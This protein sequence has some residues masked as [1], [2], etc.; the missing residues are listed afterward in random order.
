[1]S[2][3]AVDW[4]FGVAGLTSRDK[5]V[6]LRL[7]AEVDS[8]GECARPLSYLVKATNYSRSTVQ[9]AIKSLQDLGLVD[10]FL[11]RLDGKKAVNFY[12][13]N[14]KKGEKL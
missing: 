1:M 2:M 10:V 7:A 3:K 6:L 5:L 9:L 12:R 4:A 8:A 14:F 11:R 13:L